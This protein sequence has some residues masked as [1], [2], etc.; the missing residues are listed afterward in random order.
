MAQR[1]EMP[2]D[3]CYFNEL[4]E[5]HAHDSVKS[6]SFASAWLEK[7][8][9]ERNWRQMAIAYKMVLHY[10]AQPADYAKYADSMLMVA[11]CTGDDGL[12]G[13]AYLKKGLVVFERNK[14][15]ALDNYLMADRH[16]SLTPDKY[17]VHKVKYVIAE[18]KFYL[19][20]YHEAVALFRECLDYFEYENDRA[21]LN[22]LHALSLCYNRLGQI[23][24][25][26]EM[27]RRGRLA[28]KD[29]GNH[30]MDCYFDLSEAVNDF[31]KKRF[32]LSISRLKQLLPVF[33]ARKDVAN[34][35][36]A[37]Y[38]LGRNYWSKGTLGAAIP[39]LK[40]VDTAF[41]NEKYLRPELRKNYE[42][43][44]D[45]YKR[46]NDTNQKDYYI[47]RLLRADSI[48][49]RNFEYLSGRVYKVYDTRRLLEERGERENDTKRKFYY[50]FGIMAVALSFSLLAHVLI[51]N[52]NR[53]KFEIAMK[54]EPEKEKKAIEEAAKSR[55]SSFSTELAE[56]LLA[57]LE[58]FEAEHKFLHKNVTAIRLA[59]AFQTNSKYI[60]AVVKHY[61]GKRFTEYINDLRID[62]IVGLLKQQ[63]KYR[64]YTNEALAAEAGFGSTQIFTRAFRKRVGISPT[65]FVNE[66]AVLEANK[67][68]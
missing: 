51:R 21:Y 42:L 5:R 56:T 37:N 4:I 63:Q 12:I 26:D 19:G 68:P 7:A 48:L 58:K 6:A 29:F 41:V 49:D 13:A 45:Y 46:R 20:L 15:E 2:A 14:K 17:L 24:K 66:L 9:E 43:L 57:K 1:E 16:I 67:K 22:T 65:T 35:T 53:R 32:Q 31:H 28:A 59:P 50:I 8:R 61:R 54:R 30:E 18:T 25:S 3:Y 44:I 64:N 55:K 34:K 33:E 11:K 36:V 10:G 27:N 62:H 23:G 40:K 47:G 39:Y 52:R 38:Y 60:S